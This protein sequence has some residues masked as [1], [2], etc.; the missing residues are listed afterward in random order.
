MKSYVSPVEQ[1]LGSE[2]GKSSVEQRIAATLGRRET[3]D[4]PLQIDVVRLDG[5]KVR[6]DFGQVGHE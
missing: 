6:I 5:G 4:P 1:A 2:L 3:S